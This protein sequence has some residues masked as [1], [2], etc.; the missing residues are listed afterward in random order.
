MSLS[1]DIKARILE[2]ENDEL[3]FFDAISD[4]RHL[5]VSSAVRSAVTL[6]F[7]EGEKDRH[8]EFLDTLDLWTE[9]GIFSVSEKP[10]DHPKDTLLARTAPT[11]AGIWDIR[12]VDVDHGIRCLGAFAGKNIFVAL[13]WAYREEIPCFDDFV[14]DCRAEWDRLFY[15]LPPYSGATLNDYLTSFYVSKE[16]RGRR[17]NAR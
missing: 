4:R 1:D 17:K 14:I 13:I 10:D 5:V 3:H 7:P 12:C 6:P 2:L 11:A 8:A 16:T 9:E 15:P